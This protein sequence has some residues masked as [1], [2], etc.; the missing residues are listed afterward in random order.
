[1]EHS[2]LNTIE[3]LRVKKQELEQLD[4]DIQTYYYNVPK[5]FFHLPVFLLNPLS[6]LFYMQKVEC[7]HQILNCYRHIIKYEKSFSLFTFSLFCIPY[8]ER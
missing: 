5:K 7:H 1:M 4:L 6:F 3:N 2:L 8:N